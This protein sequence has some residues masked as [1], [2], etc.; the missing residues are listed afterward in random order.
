MSRNG[1]DRILEIANREEAKD[2]LRQT[3][4]VVA[5]VQQP[6][7]VESFVIK[8]PDIPLYWSSV[9]FETF[10]IDPEKRPF[11]KY[12]GVSHVHRDDRESLP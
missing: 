9:S 5:K 6:S 1:T 4:A 8:A 12:H 11:G 2:D 10:G 7:R 3:E